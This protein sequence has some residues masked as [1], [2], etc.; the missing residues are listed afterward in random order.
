VDF[1]LAT[2]CAVG[3]LAVTVE[4]CAASV[5]AFRFFVAGSIMEPLRT[6]NATKNPIVCPCSGDD[7]IHLV[8]EAMKHKQQFECQFGQLASDPVGEK[9]RE[10]ESARAWRQIIRANLEEISKGRLGEG[11]KEALLREQMSI[12][13]SKLCALLLHFP[14]CA[15]SKSS[16]RLVALWELQ[17]Q[18]LFFFKKNCDKS[19]NGL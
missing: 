5:S 3:T 4:S 14:P 19:L 17:Y 9:L 2:T 11:M 6:N 15:L 16:T 1:E 8:A 7:R 12:V 13:H 18:K 10:R